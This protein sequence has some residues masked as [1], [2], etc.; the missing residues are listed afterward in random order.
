MKRFL[1]LLLVG[2]LLALASVA[3]EPKITNGKLVPR[4]VSGTLEQELAAIT[5]N[6]PG[7]AWIGYPVPVIPGEHHMCCFDFDHYQ[8]N[9]RCCGGCRLESGNGNSVIGKI[10]DCR[11][12]EPSKIFFTLLRIQNR[13]LVKARPYSVDCELDIGGLTMYWLNGVKA[14][15]SVSLLER[16]VNGDTPL[17]KSSHPDE[18]E[19]ISAI[20]MHADASADAALDRL[21]LA[22]K[23]DEVREHAA[24]WLG[25]SRG[26]HGFEVLRNLLRIES[27]PG[28]LEHFVFAL[29]QNDD[30]QAQPELIRLARND[31]RPEVREQA[32]F[33]LAQR[34]GNKVG[35]VITE[36]IKR[37]PETEVKKKAVFALTQ[38]PESEGV[39]LLIQVAKTN[40]NPVVRKEAIFWLGQSGDARALDYIESVLAK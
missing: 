23:P 22:G 18:G 14:S 2:C 16:L 24:F 35:A 3:Q 36:A 39:P 13:Q 12:L 28:A 21:V 31:R 15:E 5:K 34:A 25:S 38:M 4:T 30:P 20:A 1:F 8:R 10:K 17:A 6:E 19:T 37:D 40:R 9:S 29:S 32:L 27:E 33:W 7:P 26:H 11:Q